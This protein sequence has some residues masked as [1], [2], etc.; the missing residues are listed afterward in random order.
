MVQGKDAWVPKFEALEDWTLAWWVCNVAGGENHGC[1]SVINESRRPQPCRDG[2][3]V[4][5]STQIPPFYVHCY[6]SHGL[7]W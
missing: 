6:R 2:K 7:I 5:L 3:H 1:E 4:T